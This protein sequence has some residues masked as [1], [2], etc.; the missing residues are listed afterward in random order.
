M[1]ALV[2]S[3]I[4]MTAIVAFRSAFFF[5][6]RPAITQFSPHLALASALPKIVIPADEDAQIKERRCFFD[7]CVCYMAQF[8]LIILISA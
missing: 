4:S 3:S 6:L 8:D 5:L 1:P 7:C 2:T